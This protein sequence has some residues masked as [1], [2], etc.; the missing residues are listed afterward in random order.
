MPL[1]ESQKA[2][3]KKYYEANKETVLARNKTYR[4]THK[5]ELRAK[6][7]VYNAV[8]KEEIRE[9]SK[10]YAKEK[11]KCDVCNKE[12]RRD[13]Y[14]SHLMSISHNSNLNIV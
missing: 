4:E 12:V 13:G 14:K 9:Y 3:Q 1:T 5:D 2:S 11:I 8:H 10:N 6:E 7:K